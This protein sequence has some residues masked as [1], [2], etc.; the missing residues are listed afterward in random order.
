MGDSDEE[1]DALVV[2]IAPLNAA[3]ARCA[4]RRRRRIACVPVT[5]MHLSCA[6][7]LSPV[8]CC[9]QDTTL[10]LAA[11]IYK[12]CTKKPSMV[13]FAN[14]YG[15]NKDVSQLKNWFGASGAAQKG[16]LY[17]VVAGRGDDCIYRLTHK[18]KTQLQKATRKSKVR[19]YTHSKHARISR[20]LIV[21]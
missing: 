6:A 11:A 16:A 3:V 10:C 2:S 17:E 18:G 14:A 19:H 4:G 7:V 8:F 9:A 5:P 1:E 20:L 15:I 13:T 12:G 21:C